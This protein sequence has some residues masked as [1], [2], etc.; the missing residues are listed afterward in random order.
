M[1]KILY[2]SSFTVRNNDF[3]SSD[4]IG[5][6]ITSSDAIFNA[7]QKKYQLI[8]IPHSA[9]TPHTL[10]HSAYLEWTIA[11]YQ[12]V[13]KQLTHTPPD[14]IFIFHSFQQFPQEIKKMLNH[15]KLKIPIIGYTHGS[16]WDPT[17]TFRHIHSPEFHLTD[18]S[19]L[20]CLD[21]ILF[22][23]KTF[24][25]VVISEIAKFNNKIAMALSKKSHV[26]GLPINTPL[27]DSFYNKKTDT[28][29]KIIFNHA[30]IPSKNLSL[31]LRV[32]RQILPH[33]PI[34]C[35]ITRD[36]KQDTQ[37]YREAKAIAD[38]NPGKLF[39]G[40]TLP[41]ADYYRLLWEADIQVSTATHESLGV[42]TLEAMYTHNCCL[43]P[44]IGA[45][46][47]ISAGIHEHLY[48]NEQE[49]VTKLKFYI[50]NKGARVDLA[51]RLASASSHYAMD[52]LYDNFIRVFEKIT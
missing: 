33:H 51:K 49:L 2:L 1:K 47:E 40:K 22:V 30:S 4:A 52:Q 48:Q 12:E 16:H 6:G 9:T 25:Q 13:L 15:L 14:A 42:A 31:F 32:I 11:S 37:E 23:T 35:Y 17:D 41:I 26:V 10:P 7:L 5:Y 38:E 29:L 44:N 43:L 28:A 45:Y 8:K 27:I 34:K 50:E 46:P 18:L 39:L 24:K 21:A 19:N 20:Y 3:D 36:I